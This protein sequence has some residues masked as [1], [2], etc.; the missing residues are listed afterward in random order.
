MNQCHTVECVDKNL[1]LCILPFFWELGLL[2]VVSE[3]SCSA[4]F[5]ISDSVC[6]GIGIVIEHVWVVRAGAHAG[7]SN[8]NK[9]IYDVCC[10]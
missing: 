2:C 8:I 10:R 6:F 4:R 3:H 5:T 9:I 1:D 7:S